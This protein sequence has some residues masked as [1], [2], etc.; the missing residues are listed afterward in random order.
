MRLVLFLSITSIGILFPATAQEKSA[1]TCRILFLAAPADAPKTIFLS[2][3]TTSQE[4]D[5]PSMNLSKVYPL[6]AG[7][8]TLTMHKALPEANVPL[9]ETAPKAKVAETLRDLYLLVASDPTNKTAPVR[10]QV[11]DANVD[12]FRNGQLLWYNLTRDRIGGK[13]G[14]Q[15]LELLPNSKVILKAPSSATGDYNVNIGY[16]PA[17]AKRSE[18]ICETVWI[19]DPKIKN[20]IFVLPVPNSRIPRI[21]GFPDYR[22]ATEESKKAP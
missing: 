18:P 8:I 14:S 3:G 2:D 1:R 9:P 5:L 21:M 19:H 7:E 6:A 11:I 12:G 22:E 13:I 16:L 15:T 10:F 17:G 4:V 20:I